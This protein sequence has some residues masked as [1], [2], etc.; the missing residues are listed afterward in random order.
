MTNFVP[1]TYCVPPHPSAKKMNNRS[2][3][4]KQKNLHTC[5][6]FQDL[7]SMWSSPLYVPAINVWSLKCL[8]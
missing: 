1:L 6:K 5:D 8:L 7:T 4:Q 2:F 3:V